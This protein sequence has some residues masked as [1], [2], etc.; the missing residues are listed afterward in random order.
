VLGAA[1]CSA[2]FWEQSAI[3]T[4]EN[5]EFCPIGDSCNPLRPSGKNI[6]TNIEV[7]LK[8]RGDAIATVFGVQLVGVTYLLKNTGQV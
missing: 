6:D 8:P 7:D 5:K 1:D 4:L 2:G 3:G